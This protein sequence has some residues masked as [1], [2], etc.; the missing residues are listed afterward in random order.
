MVEKII[1]TVAK[2]KDFFSLIGWCLSLSWK[3]SKFYTLA[4]LFSQAATPLL[5]IAASF[6]G[7]Y[8]LNL[9]SG[10]W[11]PADIQMSLLL[12]SAALLGIALLRVALDRLTKYA[13]SMHSDML[14]KDISLM[15]MDRSLSA[16]LE[17]FDNPTY[18]DK[19]LSAFRD[20]FAIPSLFWNALTSVS[21]SV[22]LIGASVV[23]GR[24]SIL[25]VLLMLPAAIPAAIISAHY[26]KAVYFMNLDQI[27]SE[28]Q[29]SYYQALAIDKRYAQ[30]LRLYNVGESLQGRYKKL[31]QDIFTTKKGMIRKKTIE[32]ALLTVLP[33][34]VIVFI[35]FDI[36]SR[37]LVMEATV[38]DYA[39]ITGLVGQLWGAVSQLTSSIMQVMDNKLRIEN[40]R[41]YEAI[42]NRVNDIGN[43]KLDRVE[44]ITFKNVSFTYPNTTQKAIDEVSFTVGLGEK[45][46]LVGVN[47]SGKTTLIKLL[48]RMYE[49]DHGIIQ[50]NDVDIREYTLDSLRK[51]FSVY[52]QDMAN[53]SFT[54]W[55]NFILTDETNP[56]PEEKM[57]QS[58]KDVGMESEIKRS[59]SGLDSFLTKY[60]N[61]DGMEL[62]GGQHQKLALARTLFR[63]HNAIILDE[64]S[65]SLDP[66]AEHDIFEILEKVTE[67]KLTIFTSHRLSNIFLADRILVL[68]NGRV[69][70]DG[71]QEQLI[72]NK[73]R[74]AELFK[75]QQTKF[76]TRKG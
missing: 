24:E 41:S 37:V 33:E 54:I 50:I 1:N 26:T 42:T 27:N 55:D 32:T 76:E 9:I 60:F 19:Q 56:N 43:R 29:L 49:P 52:F 17:F 58:I 74:F 7:K 14:K 20:S 73:K 62:S 22:S 61:K 47:G 64:P 72:K 13:Q 75:Y 38:G 63:R 68:E 15:M 21:A 6:I 18:Y 30:D 8:L 5:G 36:A 31:W 65:S 35:G 45:L 48:L 3:A 51:N 25:Y 23:L 53:F 39:L 11:T 34:I 12:L 28:R 10:S 16:D 40:L 66:K 67:D 46:A 57:L 2:I 44:K 59:R 4:Q 70:E 69:I 71:T